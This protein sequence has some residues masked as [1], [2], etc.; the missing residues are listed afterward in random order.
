MDSGMRTIRKELSSGPI[1]LAEPVANAYFY[2]PFS[3]D[4]PR[5]MLSDEELL[6]AALDSE[7][8]DFWRDAG[9]D[10]YSL[11]DGEPV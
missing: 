9:E 3:M 11:E 5:G 10:V 7:A 6:Q 1:T 4:M 8:F 2:V